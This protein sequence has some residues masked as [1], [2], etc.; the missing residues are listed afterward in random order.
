MKMNVKNEIKALIVRT[1][2]TEKEVAERLAEKYGRSSS[3]SNLSNKLARETLRF[4]E[5]VEIADVL[6]YDLEFVKRK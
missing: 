3:A 1:G 2:L 5:A 4:I 6:G